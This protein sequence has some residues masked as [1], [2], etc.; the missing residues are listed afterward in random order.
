MRDMVTKGRQRNGTAKITESA[1][2]MILAD[3]RPYRDISHDFGGLTKSSI[4]RIKLRR[5]WKHLSH[6]MAP[7]TAV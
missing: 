4:S 6:P 2:M 7:R 5:A 3:D 1:A